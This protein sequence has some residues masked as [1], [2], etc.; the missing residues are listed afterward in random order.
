MAQLQENSRFQNRDFVANWCKT[1]ILLSDYACMNQTL[2]HPAR[3]R[4]LKNTFF[5]TKVSELVFKHLVSKGG[6]AGH[7][8]GPKV[9]HSP[10]QKAHN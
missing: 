9:S 4:G 10:G 1:V 2:M 3:A 6:G 5:V 7:E 8:E